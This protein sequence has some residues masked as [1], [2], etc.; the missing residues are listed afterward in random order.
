MKRLI[1]LIVFST[2][3][4][5]HA[6][7]Q[8]ATPLQDWLDLAAHD[9]SKDVERVT[10]EQLMVERFEPFEQIDERRMVIGSLE[11][12]VFTQWLQENYPEIKNQLEGK[13]EAFIIRS[14]NT[15]PETIVFAGSDDHGA[16]RGIYHFSRT[17]LGVDPT[18][19]FTRIEPH[20]IYDLDWSAIDIFG[21]EP[22]FAYRGWFINDEDLLTGWLPGGGRR[23]IDYKH[24][25]MT[26][27]P[28]AMAKV[29]ETAVRLGYNL[30][31]P[32]SFVDIANPPEKRLVDES[33]RRGLYLS[34]HHIEPLGVNAYAFFNY[35]K[36]RGE[37]HLFSFHSSPE[38]MEETWRHYADLWSKYDHV[39]WQIGLRGIADRP[40]WMADPDTPTSD[41]VRGQIIS[42]AMAL[43]KRIIADVTDNADVTITTTLWG[44]GAHFLEQGHLDIPENVK[45][46]FS[47]NSAGRVWQDDFYNTE[48]VPEYGYGVYFHHQLWG[49]GPHAAQG[50]SPAEQEHLFRLAYEYDSHDYAII[51]ASSIRE[52]VLGL[53]A[54]SQTLLDIEAY[55]SETFMEEQ[56]AFWF[57][58]AGS[59]AAR[60]YNEFFDI[61]IENERGVPFLLDG[62]LRQKGHHAMGA[63]NTIVDTGEPPKP[64]DNAT[65]YWVNKHLRDVRPQLPEGVTHTMQM[66]EQLENLMRVYP[67]IKLAENLISI[68]CDE[69]RQRFF[70]ENLIASWHMMHALNTWA[71]HLSRAEDA[72]R[73]GDEETCVAELK[74]AV[75]SLKLIDEAKAIVTDN[76]YFATWYDGDTKMDFKEVDRRTLHT[77]RFVSQELGD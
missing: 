74:K 9:L 34:M 27:S 59:S 17:V 67:S 35:W 65:S 36:D 71:L 15:A 11:N 28:K 46:I 50:V 24:Y 4:L 48:R 62:L 8:V 23:Y 45:I 52:F 1:S 30:M 20:K 53:S 61:Y 66:E 63:I 7:I 43:Q 13:H 60:A 32:A 42:D 51:N 33:A 39:I 77:Y 14:L 49:V 68:H 69:S 64:Q 2:I 10:G 75:K 54:S 3:S 16:M 25:G 76:P 5:L 41:A 37:E 47:D 56:M 55:S 6:D 72:I 58:E 19:L 12:E 18:Y 29:A 70:R 21:D 38:Q 26:T 22:T 73:A 44:E 57:G 40:M 31:I